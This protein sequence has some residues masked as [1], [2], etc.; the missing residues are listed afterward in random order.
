MSL[1]LVA[2]TGAL[3]QSL[4]QKHATD[5]SRIYREFQVDVPVRSLGAGTRPIYPSA[6]RHSGVDAEVQ[7]QFVVDTTGTPDAAS[8]K[9]VKSPDKQFSDAVR[10][11]LPKMHYRPAE[12]GGHKVRQLVAQQFMFKPP[13]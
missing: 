8:F 5:T 10:A 9:I 11:V 1:L 4:P 6:L 7:A 12:V 3:A 2:Y 13:Q